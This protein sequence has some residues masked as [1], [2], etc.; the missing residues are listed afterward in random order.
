MWRGDKQEARKALRDNYLKY[1]RIS[2]EQQDTDF[3]EN[4]KFYQWLDKMLEKLQVLFE[5]KA[6]RLNPDV[7]KHMTYI[8]VM[9]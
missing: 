6:H 5:P 7:F 1:K 4:Y 9:N 2:I 8:W 3:R